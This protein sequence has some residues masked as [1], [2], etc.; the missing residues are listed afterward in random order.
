[1]NTNPQQHR[2][3]NFTIQLVM[4]TM[5]IVLTGTTILYNSSPRSAP[6]FLFLLA[7]GVALMSSL[8]LKRGGILALLA[9]SISIS[10][11]Q[12]VGAWVGDDLFFNLI[13]VFLM[14]VTFLIIGRY[15]DNLQ[16]YFKEF[17]D[18]KLKLK[19][20]DME[21]TSIG[22]VRPAIG[23]LR[24]KEEIDRAIRF[25]RPVSLV[26]IRIS[27]KPDNEWSESERLSAMR[28]VAT[29]VKDTTRVLDIPF[30]V[31]AEKIGLILTDTEI[32]GT[33]KVIGNI[34]RQLLDGQVIT[35]S[36]RSEALQR[37]AQIRF[38]YGV[39][40]GQSNEPFDIMDAAELSLQRNIDMNVGAIFQNLFIDWE[41]IG[42]SPTFQTIIPS[43]NGILE[44]GELVPPTIENRQEQLR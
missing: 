35:G 19:V 29:T 12:F 27:S 25:K 7:S 40:L 41:L 26:L 30:L 24:L 32:N 37:Y 43:N 13:E 5:G 42:K 21:D 20:L 14:A 9:C 38:G 11:K 15:H 39:F 31:N 34:Q 23:L 8:G 28:A 6:I 44:I 36:G 33:N 22:L 1:M 10:I 4:L 2:P 3:G 17:D 18:A 16:T